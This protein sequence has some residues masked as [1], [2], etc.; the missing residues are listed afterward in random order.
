MKDN[1]INLLRTKST[2]E[3]HRDLA[4]RAIYSVLAV[5]PG[6]SANKL[7]EVLRISRKRTLPPA[8]QLLTRLDLIDKTSKGYVAKEPPQDMFHQR[9]NTKAKHWSQTL[10]Y[11][12][13]TL[14][15][16]V[17][18]PVAAAM[19]LYRATGRT[20]RWVARR[21]AISP[22]TASKAVAAVKRSNA[23]QGEPEAL[24][25]KLAGLAA[26]YAMSIIEKCGWDKKHK[27][28]LV[29]ILLGMARHLESK[30]EPNDARTVFATTCKDIAERRPD[31][32]QCVLHCLKDYS[33]RF[34]PIAIEMSEAKKNPAGAVCT[35]IRSAMGRYLRHQK[36]TGSLPVDD[37]YVDRQW[38]GKHNQDFFFAL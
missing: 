7:A 17:T 5:S 14:V 29:E 25:S 6:L 23:I 27:T 37:F 22:T 31:N 11:N 32:M 38:S 9:D 4:A 16:D 3:L 33:E 20:A 35:E 26:K 8:L 2:S 19:S 36:D 24:K 1:E 15:D 21:L 34:L 10:A 30:F 12:R 18:F 28:A 13:I